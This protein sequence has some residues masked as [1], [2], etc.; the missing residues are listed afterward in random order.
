MGA[1]RDCFQQMLLCCGAGGLGRP[2]PGG[3]GIPLLSM[4]RNR[5]RV[6]FRVTV[7]IGP[8]W[9]PV[10]RLEG[11]SRKKRRPRRVSSKQIL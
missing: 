4:V 5:I 2:A 10:G 1:A 6:M 3:D 11:F 9:A 7:M 8:Q